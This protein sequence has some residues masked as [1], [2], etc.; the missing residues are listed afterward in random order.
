MSPNAKG[1]VLIEELPENNDQEAEVHV[2]S[3]L[4]NMSHLMMSLLVSTC[5]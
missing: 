3:P 4:R 5:L 2:E 1:K